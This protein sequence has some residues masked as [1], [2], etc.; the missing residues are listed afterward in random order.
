MIKGT[1]AIL[2]QEW[3][4]FCFGLGLGSVDGT[5][6]NAVNFLPGDRVDEANGN[7]IRTRRNGDLLG[8]CAGHKGEEGFAGVIRCRLVENVLQGLDEQFRCDI[9]GVSFACREGD[10]AIHAGCAHDNAGEMK[11]PNPARLCW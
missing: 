11:P 9:G 4:A 10:D 2:R 1:P 8:E 7:R 3:R 6:N 5:E